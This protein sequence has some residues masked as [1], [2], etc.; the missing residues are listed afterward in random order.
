VHSN[1]IF[2]LFL[3]LIDDCTCNAPFCFSFLILQERCTLLLIRW[4]IALL[5]HP[6]GSIEIYTEGLKINRYCYIKFIE[7]NIFDKAGFCNYFGHKY[8]GISIKDVITSDTN[9][10]SKW[11]FFGSGVIKNITKWSINSQKKSTGFDIIIPIYLFQKPEEVINL[12]NQQKTG[13]K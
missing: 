10:F 12:L 8:I 7:W 9:L 2:D 5:L 1:K 4:I 6:R 11:S 3:P 13:Y